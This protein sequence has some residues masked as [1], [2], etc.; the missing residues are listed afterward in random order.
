MAWGGL[1]SQHFRRLCLL[2]A[3]VLSDRLESLDFL[4]VA[5]VMALRESPHI[6]V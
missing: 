1:C 6:G 4:N 3:G 5:E 2:N